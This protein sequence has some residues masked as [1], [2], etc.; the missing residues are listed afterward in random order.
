MRHLIVHRERALACFAMKYDCVLDR[1]QAD[2]LAE[3]E[4]K[5]REELMLNAPGVPMRNGETITIELDEG[6]HRFFAAACLES[7]TMTTNDLTI[8]AGD[9]D[10][11]HVGG[12]LGAGERVGLGVAVRIDGAQ[13]GQVT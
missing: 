13:V 3:L 4:G 2:F 9:A 12:A 7:R 11:D 10:A 8:P 1:E 6:E 5:D